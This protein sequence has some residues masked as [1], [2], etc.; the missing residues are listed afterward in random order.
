MD[1]QQIAALAIVALAALW[2][3]RTRLLALARARLWRRFEALLSRP[4]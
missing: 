2:L 4:A 1:W 3:V